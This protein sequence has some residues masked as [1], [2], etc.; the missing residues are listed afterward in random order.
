MGSQD[1]QVSLAT[2][3]TNQALQNI[4]NYCTITCTN[5]VNNVDITIIGGD[6][7]INLE[8]TCSAVGAECIVKNVIQSQIDNMIDN[9]IKQQ[10]SNLGIFSLLGPSSTESTN[11]SNAIKNQVSQ[12][13][14]NN[15]AISS[16]NQ[17]TN[18]SIFAQ[19]AATKLNFIQNGNVSKA[20]CALDTVAKL[21]LN[22]QVTN[23]VSQGESSC[24]DILWILIVVSVIILLILLFPILSAVFGTAGRA[25][26]GVGRV[27]P[28]DKK[29]NKN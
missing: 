24:G 26:K 25:V 4:S 8:Q 20:S 15:C 21:V 1:E 9:M 2:N 7:T 22:N 29:T 16:D 14:T 18:I 11:I 27:I 12:L 5:D 23:S 10:E 3:I 19:D 17:T 13:I 6:T 28:A